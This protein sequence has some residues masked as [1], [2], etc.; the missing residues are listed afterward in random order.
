MGVLRKHSSNL[1]AMFGKSKEKNV[2]EFN[3]ARINVAKAINLANA[4]R[5]RQHIDEMDEGVVSL[6]ISEHEIIEWFLKGNMKLIHDIWS[7]ALDVVEPDFVLKNEEWEKR[8]MKSTAVILSWMIAY[9]FRLEDPEEAGVTPI[10]SKEK[11]LCIFKGDLGFAGYPPLLKKP[12][13]WGGRRAVC[14]WYGEL[15]AIQE[16]VEEQLEEELK[17]ELK[18]A[19]TVAPGGALAGGYR[20]CGYRNYCRVWGFA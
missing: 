4:K 13:T 18:K 8:F 12:E 15:E 7:T 1:L 20:R 16:Q 5:S 17:E 10:N 14:D 2:Q 6:N 19:I 9:T 3:A 11:T